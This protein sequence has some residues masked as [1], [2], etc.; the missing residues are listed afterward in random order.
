VRLA[1][2]L[3]DASLENRSVREK[4]MRTPVK[5]AVL[6]FV[7]SLLF[8]RM[9]AALECGDVD[10]S[11]AVAA[12][13][14]LL[15]LRNAVGQTGGLVCPQSQEA[16]VEARVTAIEELLSH[17]TVEGD[18][19]VLS[20]MNLQIVNGTGATDGD[21][22]DGPAVNGLGN[23]IIGYD[24]PEADT[25]GID[26]PDIDE[27]DIDEPDIDEPGSDDRNFDGSEVDA[28]G[29]SHNLVIGA[30][31]TYTSFGGIVAGDDNEIAGS[32]ASVLGGS[33]NKASGEDSTIAGGTFNRA[34]AEDSSVCGGLSNDA[35]GFASAVLGGEFNR[36]V[37]DRSS[38]SGGT[39]NLAAGTSSSVSGGTLNGAF[40]FASTVGGGR[41]RLLDGR[42]SWR[43][44]AL[45]EPQ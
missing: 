2:V 27:P 22:G 11:G 45:I 32:G 40:A 9:A 18:N 33:Q 39:D 6:L 15:V 31:H 24:E 7:A 28:K 36:A 12:S 14:A 25:D 4:N 1:T 37:G 5:C 30:G 13:D 21:V 41:G 38:V 16:T 3:A 19:L 29:G 8:P 44:G 23:L 26:E 42:W 43:A 17:F 34:I 10:G 35:Q 20:G